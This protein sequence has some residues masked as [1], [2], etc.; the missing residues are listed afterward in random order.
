M[1]PSLVEPSSKQIEQGPMFAEDRPMLAESQP[2]PKET[3]M[4]ANRTALP[5][6]HYALRWHTSP[7]T[8]DGLDTATPAPTSVH[9]ALPGVQRARAQGP[10]SGSRSGGDQAG[11]RGLSHYMWCS[12]H[13]LDHLRVRRPLTPRRLWRPEGRY[14]GRE[15]GVPLVAFPGGGGCF[16]AIHAIPHASVSG[17]GLWSKRIT[18]GRT[19]PRLAETRPN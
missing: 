17:C 13:P 14:C 16:A 7:E 19:E 10:R 1:E 15:G 6:A 2:R 5:F 9:L 18:T 8:R 11:P 12:A 4:R 3:Q